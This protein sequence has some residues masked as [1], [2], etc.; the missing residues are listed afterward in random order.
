MACGLWPPTRARPPTPASYS[1]PGAR[2]FGSCKSLEYSF[3]YFF[4]IEFSEVTSGNK[5]GF[6]GALHCGRTDGVHPPHPAS[7]HHH[8]SPR[9][10]QLHGKFSDL[11]LTCGSLPGDRFPG[12]EGQFPWESWTPSSLFTSAHAAMF[13]TC[14]PDALAGG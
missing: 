11:R 4:L 12:A 2:S 9:P 13:Q 14:P 1:R 7:F 5:T 6:Q 8:S 3:V 10:L